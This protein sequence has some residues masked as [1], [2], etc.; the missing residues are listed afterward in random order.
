MSY[1]RFFREAE[2]YKISKCDSC[3]TSLRR[4][5]KVYAYLVLMIVVLGIVVLPALF[6]LVEAKISFW[7]IC[8][9]I[10]IV[11]AAWTLLTNYL[12]WRFVGWVLVPEEKK[13]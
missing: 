6:M 9:A 2:P 7:I 10:I 5:P 1:K 12:A 13:S 4:N 3:A 11:L 8:S